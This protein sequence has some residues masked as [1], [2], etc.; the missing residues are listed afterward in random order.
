[1]LESLEELRVFV[2]IVESRSI[3]GAA[4]A[5]GLPANTVS[6]R[7]V[8]LEE[9]L[10]T[11]L[12]NRSTRSQSLT[13]AGRVFLVRARRILEEVE[14]TEQLMAREQEQLSGT[15]RVSV[16]SAM[17]QDVLRAARPLMAEHPGLRIL[18]RTHERSINPVTAGL[19]VAFVGGAIPDSALVARKLLEVRSVLVASKDYLERH[20]KP[21]TPQD[22]G[23]HHLVSFVREPPVSSWVLTGADGREHVVPV[24]ARL[25]V[26]SSRTMADALTQG[27]GIGRVAPRFLRLGADLERVL[28]DYVQG[29][30]PLFA[31]YPHSKHRSARVQAL[32]DALQSSLIADE[33]RPA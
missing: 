22:L 23:D 11:K 19:D 16:I 26:D 17:A 4:R 32:V 27:L 3:V 2:Q 1:M 20:G 25:E 13:E 18:L 15:I 21:K 5:Q 28:P 6:R 10:A 8:A 12:L 7:L 29:A 9:R 24:D 33:A 30:F 14:D 31:V